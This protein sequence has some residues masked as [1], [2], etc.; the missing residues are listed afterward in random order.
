MFYQILSAPAVLLPHNLYY[1]IK[2]NQKQ[3]GL[4]KWPAVIIQISV[5]LPAAVAVA[6]AAII[7]R[8]IP[9]ATVDAAETPATT[10]PAITVISEV[11]VFSAG[12]FRWAG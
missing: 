2:Q 3:G 10:A 11:S 5:T 9:A 1:K 6:A 4:I 12:S 7:T 8:E